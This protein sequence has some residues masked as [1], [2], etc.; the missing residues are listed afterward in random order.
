MF[1]LARVY[2]AIMSML[3]LR[4]S[5]RSDDASQQ[6]HVSSRKQSGREIIFSSGNGSCQ[7]DHVMHQL[8][9]R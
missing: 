3:H 4:N 5:H 1:R 8:C 9:V 7:L 2:I 6:S